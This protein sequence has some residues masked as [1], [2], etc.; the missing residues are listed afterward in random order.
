MQPQAGLM[1]ETPG[2]ILGKKVVKAAIAVAGLLI[3]SAIVSALPMVRNAPPIYHR[4]WLD[5]A[6]GNSQASLLSGQAPDSGLALDHALQHWATLAQSDPQL[7]GTVSSTTAYRDN[8]RALLEGQRGAVAAKALRGVLRAAGWAIFPLDAV[9]AAIATLIFLV[10]F[11]LAL[12]LRRGIEESP[13]FAE[14]GQAAEMGVLVVIA[15]LAYGA[16]QTIAFPL[17]G[18]SMHAAYGWVFFAAGLIPLVWGALVA[19]NLDAVTASA[20]QPRAPRATRPRCPSC[21]G[22]VDAGTRF[23]PQC[24]MDFQ[25]AT[26]SAVAAAPAAARLA[27]QACGAEA[28]PGARF[29]GVCG[30]PLG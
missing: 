30:G 29:C 19:R 26:A 23:C 6:P 16:Y 12:D 8:I 9:H 18:A 21:G 5:I 3:I 20:F 15:A 4:S 10:L 13:R 1:V 2:R 24:G 17:L 22:A 27:C 25:A 28:K 11:G 14:L 7:L